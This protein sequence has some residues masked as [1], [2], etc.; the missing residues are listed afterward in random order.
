MPVASQSPATLAVSTMLFARW[1]LT[2]RLPLS[3][4]LEAVKLWPSLTKADGNEF[5][6]SPRLA[7]GYAAE[8]VVQLTQENVSDSG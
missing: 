5:H 3:P 1:H 6:P 8:A 2:A 7:A 4:C